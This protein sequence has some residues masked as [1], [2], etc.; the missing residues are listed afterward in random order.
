M[1]N[2]TSRQ[3]C[4]TIVAMEKQQILYIQRVCL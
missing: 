2:A 4:V 1:Y 3:I